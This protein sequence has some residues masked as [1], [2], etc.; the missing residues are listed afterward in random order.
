MQAIQASQPNQQIQEVN[1][2]EL[3][4]SQALV[5]CTGN[6]ANLV[7]STSSAFSMHTLFASRDPQACLSSRPQ[8][9][10]GNMKLEQYML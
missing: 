6:V 2:S 10:F 7:T 8:S 5:V 3:S 1:H 9:S 4:P